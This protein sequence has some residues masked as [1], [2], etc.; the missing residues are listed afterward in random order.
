[1]AAFNI[2][3]AVIVPVD[4]CPGCGDRLDAEPTGLVM[5]VVPDGDVH[6]K[7]AEEH[8]GPYYSVLIDHE[9]NADGGLVYAER[10][11]LR[12]GAVA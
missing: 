2:G 5:R 8:P 1:M 7:L 3:D 10:E 9:H 4:Y 11:L 6:W 12:A